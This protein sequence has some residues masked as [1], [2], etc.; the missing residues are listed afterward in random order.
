MTIEYKDLT[1]NKREVSESF[2]Q[3]GMSMLWEKI[4]REGNPLVKELLEEAHMIMSGVLYGTIESREVV[5]LRK[6]FH[7]IKTLMEQIANNNDND[8]CPDCRELRHFLK[9]ELELYDNE[10]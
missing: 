3:Y 9:G 8:F 4:H 1:G 7:D 5:K 10:D 2:S 6:D